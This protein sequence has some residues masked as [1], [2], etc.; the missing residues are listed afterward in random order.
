MSL[1]AA[2]GGGG[3]YTPDSRNEITDQNVRDIREM[4]HEEGFRQVEIAE[5]FAIS[6]SEVSRIINRKRRKDVT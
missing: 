1:Y 6:Q 4:Y 2:L 5:Y 3:E